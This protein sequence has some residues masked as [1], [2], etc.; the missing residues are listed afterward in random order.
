MKIS[1]AFLV[2]TIFATSSIYAQTG[3]QPATKPTNR[4]PAALANVASAADYKPGP[5]APGVIR[6]WGNDFMTRLESIWEEGFRKFHPEIRFEDTLKSSAQAV[7]ALYTNV[8]DVGLL[9]REPWPMEVL[10]FQKMFNY[11]PLAIAAATGSFDAEGKTWPFIIF[12]NKS[13]PIQH[14]DLQQLDA[15]FGTGLKRGAKVPITRWGQLGLTGEWADR[16]IHV[17]GYDMQIPGFTYGFQQ[18]V[19]MG[20]DK[21]TGS[22]REFYNTHYPD[23]RLIHTGGDLMTAE[24][25]KDEDA[26]GFTGMQFANDGVK[27]LPISV[28]S[29]GPYI[30][31]NVENTA[32]RTYPMVRAIYILVNRKPGT[33]LDPKLNE[34]LHYV[35][36]KQ[37]QAD[38]LKEGD[39]LPMPPEFLAE[40]LKK[41]D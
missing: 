36:S 33:P 35:L 6:V 40:Q 39:F 3:S 38:V 15:I 16:P 30:T 24:I 13:N 22:L 5:P 26:I 2:G 8:A 14:L 11:D 10:G 1:K 32:N 12:V 19:F 20:S 7:G 23:G 28:N 31:P 25:A 21:W 4:T 17:N 29:G 27:F 41:L 37:G 9:G 18:I 34:F